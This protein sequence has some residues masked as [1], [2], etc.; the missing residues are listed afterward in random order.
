MNASAFRLVGRSL[1]TL[2]ATWLL[3]CT[4]GWAFSV[5]TAVY[6]FD[7]S[8]AAAVGLVVAARL[9]PA[10]VAAPLTGWLIDRIGRATVV[11][12]ACAV[13]AACVGASAAIMTAHGGLWPII[14]LAAATGIAATAPRPALEA[15]LP[16]LAKTPEE[17]TRATAAWGAIDN[18]GFL[19]GG[20]A[21]AAAIGVLGA[22]AVTGTAACLF[23]IASFLALRL[24][25]VTATDTDEPEEEMAGLS[26]AL[27][28][29]RTLRH[30]PSLRTAFALLA[31]LLVVEGAVEVQIPALA[32]GHL[33]MGN[34]GPGLLYAVWGIGGVLASGVLLALVRWRG[35]GLA[36]LVGCFSFA[37]G[38]GVSGV[39]GVAVAL[40]AMLPAGIGMAL[41]E[42]GF[43]ALV[44]RLADDAV[45]GRMYALSEIAYSGAAGIGA[46]IAPALIHALGVPGSLAATSSA[47][48]LLAVGTSGTMARLDTGQEQASR[49]RELL[50][51]VSF[52]SPLPLPRLERLVRGAHSIEVP[53]GTAVVT[54]GE[55]GSDFYVVDDGSVQIEVDGRHVGP[56]SAFGEIALLLDVPRV[57]TVRAV[58]D[59]R[60]WAITRRAFVA[61]VS[62]HEDVARLADA[63]VREHLARP[64]VT[65][66][67][68]PTTSSRGDKSE[69]G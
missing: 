35:Y 7:R 52:L 42:V 36:L 37:V 32:I 27:A 17:L 65:D 53:A 63:T 39:D 31:G 61:A 67:G 54:A 4:A 29:I 38:V 49:V 69:V 30:T 57:T 33:H 19:L 51:G 66:S 8:G 59:V 62:A 68:S 45:A 58:T 47:F 5:A 13:E 44:P 40:L 2:L 11:A 24:P 60:L 20:G 50:H 10:M 1:W 6:A 15:L 48:G 12:G 16:A 23:A 28:G 26:E 21:G 56:G 34:G 46:L 9:L 41:V 64:S 55:P 25:W 3:A 43:M 22:G 14:V 18:G